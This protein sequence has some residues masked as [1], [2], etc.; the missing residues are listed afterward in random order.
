[1]TE[2]IVPVDTGEGGEAPVAPTTPVP[3]ENTPRDL[4]TGGDDTPSFALPDEYKEK[5]WAKNIKSVD[6]LWK[7]YDNAQD[8]IGKKTIG[9]IDE[10]STP[11]QIQEYYAKTRPE[12]AE[13]YTFPEDTS[14]DEKALYSKA[15]F[16]NGISKAQA[17][18]IIKDHSDNVAKQ[19]EVLFSADGFEK[20]MKESFGADTEAQPT[21]KALIDKHSN[22]VDKTI[23]NTLTNEQA[24]AMYRL[25][26]NFSKAHGKQEG[27]ALNNEAGSQNLSETQVKDK[28]KAIRAKVAELETRPHDASEKTA[29]L[30][31]LAA[32]YKGVK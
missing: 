14:D 19:K 28:Q 32:T 22:D 4:T 16:D 27:G 9:G 5:G 30:N 25:T 7:N 29:L 26:N 17:E 12:N 18:G 15:F 24:G 20:V 8:L 10:N 2:E 6:D 3:A 11:D 1:M 31:D 21:T 23:L 13:A